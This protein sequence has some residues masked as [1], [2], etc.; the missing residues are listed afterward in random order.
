VVSG[1]IEC[2][3]IGAS[4]CRNQ[5]NVSFPNDQCSQVQVLTLNAVSGEGNFNVGVRNAASGTLNGYF[6]T[7]KGP[8]GSSATLQL[9]KIVAGIVTTLVAPTTET[10]NSGDLVGICAQGTTVYVTVRGS[11]ISALTATDGSVTAGIPA[12]GIDSNGQ[13]ETDV[14]LDNWSGFFIG[15]TIAG[16]GGGGM[17]A[18]KWHPGHYVLSNTIFTLGSSITTQQSEIAIVRAAPSQ[19]L[20]YTFWTYWRP[21]ENGGLGVYDFSSIDKLYVQLLTGST[22]WTGGA[23]PPLSSPRRMMIYVMNEDFFHAN[24]TSEMLPDYI[25]TSSTYGPLG[26]DGTHYGYWC[27][28]GS[29]GSCTGSTAAFYR[30]SVMG[31][32]IALD[33][34]IGAHTL[35]DGN[36]ID[37]SPYI[38][39]VAVQGETAQQPSS[40]TPDSTYSVANARTQLIALNTSMGPA[41]SSVAFPHTNVQ[42]MLNYFGL[43]T[44]ASSIGQTL[45]SSATS[46]GGSDTVG[47]SSGTVANASPCSVFLCGLTPGQG[48][49]AGQTPS[50]TNGNPWS[51]SGSTDWRG[52]LPGIYQ[53]QGT[54]L[55]DDATYTPSDIFGQLNTT[56]HATHAVWSL[57]PPGTFTGGAINGNFWGSCSSQS[58]WNATPSACGGVLYIITTDTLSTTACPSYYTGGCNT[59][60]RLPSANDDHFHQMLDGRLRE[61]A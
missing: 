4:D 40:G 7:A 34:A 33:Q 31:R 50:G 61:A 52:K 39:A 15:T 37:T 14:I 6:V 51:S 56:I 9:F 8:L 20:G 46:F 45:G 5:Y 12:I 23:M 55:G 26:P 60:L 49:Y 30:S 21:L 27:M 11:Q 28:N 43:D 41:G 24:P 1:T 59:S 42:F 3:S 57:L 29:G 22:T 10:I 48:T 17:A 25:A 38:E 44:D 18:V 16:G 53:I 58:A 35:P 19:V 36:T 32:Q 47:I 13:A 54:E 2:A